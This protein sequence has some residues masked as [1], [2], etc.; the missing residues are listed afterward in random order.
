[1]SAETRRNG[2]V[3]TVLDAGSGDETGRLLHE[4]GSI[5]ESVPVGPG[6]AIVFTDSDT[7]R[8]IGRP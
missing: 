8:L 4:D 1:M 2:T 7:M 6:Q 5:W 3:V